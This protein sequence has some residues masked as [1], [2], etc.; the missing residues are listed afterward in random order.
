MINI[1][2]LMFNQLLHKVMPKTLPKSS[3][4]PYVK[5]LLLSFSVFL[6]GALNVEFSRGLP[7]IMQNL[8]ELRNKTGK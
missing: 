5:I 2:N 1:L 4:T 8:T 3:V 6:A 7:F